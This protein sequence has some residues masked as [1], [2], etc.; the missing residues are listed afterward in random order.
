MQHAGTHPSLEILWDLTT[1]P[2][3]L[4]FTLRVPPLPST[5]QPSMTESGNK[6]PVS[7]SDLFKVVSSGK[8]DQILE[9]VRQDEVSLGMVDPTTGR[10]QQSLSAQI[11]IKILASHDFTS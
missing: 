9:A 1:C 3:Y 10:Y 6:S 7:H 5:Q 2:E 8:R 11:I 4:Q